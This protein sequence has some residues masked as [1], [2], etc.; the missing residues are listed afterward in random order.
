LSNYF[1]DILVARPHAQH[2][3]ENALR[4]RAE[5]SMVIN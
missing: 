3:V 2:I 5:N 1:L 4:L